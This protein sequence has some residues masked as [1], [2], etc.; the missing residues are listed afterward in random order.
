MCVIKLLCKLASYQVNYDHIVVVSENECIC[1]L[2]KA[3]VLWIHKV[4]VL[5]FQK[6]I[7]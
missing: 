1:S 6:F 7:V 2:S 5:R 4:S 3:G